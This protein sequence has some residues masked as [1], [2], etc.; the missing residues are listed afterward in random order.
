M[1]VGNIGQ[2][3]PLLARFLQAD[4]T[5]EATVDGV[6]A[7]SVVDPGVA[8]IREV[9]GNQYAYIVGEGSTTVEIRVDADRG[10]GVRELV[11]VGL[12]V[13]NDPATEAQTVEVDL[14]PAEDVPAEEPPSA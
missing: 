7:W 3:V 5:S 10:A 6:P 8:E 4:G 9:N 1:A 14:G 13:G 12:I 2:R 11:G